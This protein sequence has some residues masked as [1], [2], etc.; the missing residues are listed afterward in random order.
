MLQLDGE[1]KPNEIEEALELAKKACDN[2]L[3][4]QRKALKEKYQNGQYY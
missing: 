4:I 2:I 3:E 1:I